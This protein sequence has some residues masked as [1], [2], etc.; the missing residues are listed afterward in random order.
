MDFVQVNGSAFV[1]GGQPFG[2]EGAN[3]YYLGFASDFMVRD[4][5]DLAETMRCNTLR[6]WAFWHGEPDWSRLDR[7]I[8]WAEQRGIRLIL[9]LVNYWT[10]F[11]GMTEWSSRS[12]FDGQR[13]FYTEPSVR[14][15]FAT[16]VEGLLDRENTI[17]G[18]RYR[19]EPAILAWELTNEARC[20]GCDPEIVVDWMSAF[21]SLVKA[22]GARQLVSAGDEGYFGGGNGMDHDAILSVPAI[23]FGTFHLYADEQPSPGDY[24]VD[25]IRAHAE[26]AQR[27]GKPTILEEYGSRDA[28]ARPGLYP[29]WTQAAADAGVAG[30]LVWMI[31]GKNDDGT[32]Y[33]DDGYTIYA[34]DGA[35]LSS[36]KEK[37]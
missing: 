3:C 11:G 23:D 7:T 5:F 36:S 8:A 34:A 18:R 37:A 20:D 21:G 12:G 32:R 15:T 28:A 31:A 35:L 33:Y 4:V 6:T 24:G 30:R 25:W 14:S 9:A 29:K 17:T 26:A 27:A 19:E 13:A 2:L 1:A 10:D 16:Y 22:A